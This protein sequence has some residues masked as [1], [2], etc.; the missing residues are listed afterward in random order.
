MTTR[1]TAPGPK[2]A[3]DRALKPVDLAGRASTGSRA[4]CRCRPRCP[5][6][7]SG[8]PTR[9]RTSGSPGAAR[10]PRRRRRPSPASR[11]RSGVTSG[12]SQAPV[13]GG[14][15]A[16]SMRSTTTS[17]IHQLRTIRALTPYFAALGSGGS[18]VTLAEQA[19][20]SAGGG[21]VG[22][23]RDRD[24]VRPRVGGDR[25][26]VPQRW[27]AAARE[28][29]PE[30][31]PQRY[32]DSEPLRGRWHAGGGEEG[33]S[34]PTRRPTRCSPSATTVCAG[35]TEV[36]MFGAG[37]PIAAGIRPLGDATSLT[38]S[39]AAG[40]A[41][42]IEPFVLAVAQGPGTILVLRDAPMR[43]GWTGR[44][45]FTQEYRPSPYLAP[46]GRWQG[47]PPESTALVLAR[48][49]LRAGVAPPRP[50]HGGRGWARAGAWRVGA[51][52]VAHAP[53]RAGVPRPG[54]P[55]ACPTMTPPEDPPPARRWRFFPPEV[56]ST[57][58]QPSDLP[59]R[60]ESTA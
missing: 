43:W 29:L 32:G 4:A 34:R 24:L 53:G 6:R 18:S 22:A 3:R 23:R 48:S 26:G 10:R 37:L 14:K 21:G 39:V 30:A 40:A 44:T 42:A 50:G 16:S 9:S 38:L 1:S 28:H 58:P 52:G 8:P 2:P 20:A 54:R 46:H 31:I 17:P 7:S 45:L 47:L 15:I 12:R 19:L 27:V 55:S 57:S 49:R 13:G 33:S 60:G 59:Q 35:P 56:N 5:R 11:A 41:A 25:R 36:R 51:R